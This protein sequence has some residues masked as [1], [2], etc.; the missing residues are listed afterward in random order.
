VQNAAAALRWTG[1]WYE[2]LVAIDPYGQTGADE[3][4]L[5]EVTGYLYPFRRMG[6]DLR[7]VLSEYAPLDL[8]L[9]ICVKPGYLAGH[10]KAALLERFSNRRLPGGAL[11]FFHPD[12]LTFGEG[13]RLSQ[14]VAV[15]Q[16]VAGV[17]SVIVERCHRL[18]ESDISVL[19]QGILHLEPMEVVRL[20]N[21][22]NFP[23]NGKLE[24]IMKGGR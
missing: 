14:I 23:E 16:A 3:T 12:N 22:P 10:V 18:F 17:E 21:D 19:E 1:S 20:D 15:A 6:H 8:A 4:L 7:V 2:V 13:V 11:G 9:T 24:L 5:A